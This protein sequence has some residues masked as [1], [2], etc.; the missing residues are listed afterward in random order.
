MPLSPKTLSA[1][2]ARARLSDYLE[3]TLDPHH[4]EQIKMLLAQDQHLAA[5]LQALEHTLQ[6]LHEA[7]RL[8]A[9]GD[10]SARVRARLT[11]A[12]PPERS[13]RRRSPRLFAAV[14]ACAALGLGVGLSLSAGPSGGDPAVQ[15]A[16]IS[17]ISEV[18]EFRMGLPG[19]DARAVLR[20]AAA[21]GVQRVDE[22]RLAF[23]GDAAAMARFVQALRTDAGRR[24]VDVSGLTPRGARSRLWVELSPAPMA[25]HERTEVGPR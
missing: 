15:A 18:P 17:G 14:A 3:G 1:A 8:R 2:D 11:P 24:G 16:G 9:P 13:L 21:A 5:E 12:E 25:E 4:Q 7:P 22:P 6:S 20:L 10:L 19:G 23:E